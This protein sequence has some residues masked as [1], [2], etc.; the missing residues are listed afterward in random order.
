MGKKLN[1]AEALNEESANI[2]SIQAAKKRK[3]ASPAVLKTPRPASREN[4][5][6]LTTWHDPDVIKQLKLIG[7]DLDVSQQDM[8]IE[9]LNTFFVKHGK[10]QIA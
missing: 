5:K 7:L 3:A 6:A 8:V 1:L 4:K 10:A 2:E 9:M